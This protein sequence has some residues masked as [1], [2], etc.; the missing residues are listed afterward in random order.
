MIYA[1]RKL[2][3][4]VFTTAAINAQIAALNTV[5]GLVGGNAVPNVAAVADGAQVEPSELTSLPA[6]LHYVGT[7]PAPGETVRFGKRDFPSMPLALAYHTKAQTKALARIHS[8]I[9]LEALL[10][11]LESLQG[12]QFG[13]T[14][15]QIVMVEDP[16]LTFTE[17]ELDGVGIRFGGTLTCALWARTQGA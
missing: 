1:A 12:M 2:V 6:V 17:F 11:V 14:L 15:R 5:Y 16:T 4:Q 3:E 10:P 8:D 9:T 7:T 13:S